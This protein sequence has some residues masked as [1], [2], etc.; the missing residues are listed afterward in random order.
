VGLSD[1]ACLDKSHLTYYDFVF[2][3]KLGIPPWSCP[4]CGFN[5]EPKKR[6]NE[7]LLSNTIKKKPGSSEVS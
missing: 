5:Q 1:R 7:N 6:T 2:L 4:S 3:C